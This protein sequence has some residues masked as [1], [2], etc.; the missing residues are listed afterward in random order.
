MIVDVCVCIQV[1]VEVIPI[2]EVVVIKEYTAIEIWLQ[3]DVRLVK[4]LIRTFVE[5]G[6]V[7]RGT[8]R[9]EY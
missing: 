3:V 2:S 7:T 1:E 4:V 8:E 9:T 6:D 5:T